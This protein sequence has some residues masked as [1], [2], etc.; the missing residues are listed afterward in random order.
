MKSRF[1]R[2][3][4]KVEISVDVAATSCRVWVVQGA[5]SLTNRKK[6]KMKIKYW[7]ACISRVQNKVIITHTGNP[8]TNLRDA[9]K[10]KHQLHSSNAVVVKAG[11]DEMP[12]TEV[13]G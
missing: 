4:K 1:W 10:A 5:N 13:V 3:S 11:D 6:R 7:T 2:A 8:H 9:K 12:T